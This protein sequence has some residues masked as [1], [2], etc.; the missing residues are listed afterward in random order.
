MEDKLDTLN[1]IDEVNLFISEQQKELQKSRDAK[2]VIEIELYN[3]QLKILELQKQI[4]DLQIQKNQL[5]QALNKARSVV[6]KIK[7]IVQR[8]TEKYWRIRG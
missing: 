4:K 2:E 3:L 6:A 5:D 1:T 8:A 7:L